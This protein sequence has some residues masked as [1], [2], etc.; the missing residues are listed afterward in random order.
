MLAAQLAQVW[1]ASDY[2]ANVCIKSPAVF[3]LQMHDAGDLSRPLHEE[4]ED[5]LR[6]RLLP[7]DGALDPL[8]D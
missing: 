7:T 4:Y 6:D 3:V 5:R 8:K 1:A 2:A